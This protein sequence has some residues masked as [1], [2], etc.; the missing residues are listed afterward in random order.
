LYSAICFCVDLSDF[1]RL[2][3]WQGR[4][5]QGR[6]GEG[7]Y[8]DDENASRG[9]R[10][11][12]KTLNPKRNGEAQSTSEDRITDRR[13]GVGEGRGDN[14]SGEGDQAEW[15]VEDEEK[16]RARESSNAGTAGGRRVRDLPGLFC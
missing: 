10:E 5:G 15:P 7:R 12:R 6:G 2:N 1:I 9:K 8:R 14:E 13:L 3:I 11:Q 16:E 4:A